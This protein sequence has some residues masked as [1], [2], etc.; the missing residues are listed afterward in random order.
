MAYLARPKELPA[1]EKPNMLAKYHVT[2][3]GVELSRK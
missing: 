3:K 1:W 2:T